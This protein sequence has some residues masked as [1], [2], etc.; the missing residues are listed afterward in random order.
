MNA[1]EDVH[2]CD[3]LTCQHKMLQVSPQFK[4]KLSKMFTDF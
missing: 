3:W 2:D 1:D 4:K